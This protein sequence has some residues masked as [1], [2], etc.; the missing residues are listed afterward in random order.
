MSPSH[1]H[2]DTPPQLSKV[3]KVQPPTFKSEVSPLILP[4]LLGNVFVC[5]CICG[6]VQRALLPKRHVQDVPL[7]PSDWPL[8]GPY[9]HLPAVLPQVKRFQPE[10]HRFSPSQPTQSD[11]LN[12]EC[13]CH[14][15]VNATHIKYYLDIY[16]S[17][18]MH[19]TQCVSSKSS[20]S[21]RINGHFD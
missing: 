3:Q 13:V 21:T 5:V 20:K 2:P 10:G 11:R 6:S 8:S 15:K 14:R 7:G 9:H 17:S 16:I 12:F 4:P 19:K 18:F 1:H